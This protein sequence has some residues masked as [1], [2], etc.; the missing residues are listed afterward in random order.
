MVRQTII[1][2]TLKYGGIPHYSFPVQLR[3]KERELVIVEGEFGRELVHHTR[4]ITVPVQNHSLEFYW[5]GRPYNVAAEIAPNGTISRYYCNVTLPPDVLGD[6]I[7]VVDLDLDLHVGPDL[8]VQVLDRD[9]FQQNA[10]RYGYPPE[11]AAGAEAALQE[12]IQLVETRSF[13]FDGEAARIGAL[14]HDRT[15]VTQE[16]SKEDQ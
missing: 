4:G 13:P 10:R 3:S 9:E 2:Q 1:V 8:Q 12:L 15:R 16:R 7:M 14:L 5:P 11:V 6:R